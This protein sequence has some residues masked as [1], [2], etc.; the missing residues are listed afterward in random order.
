MTDLPFISNSTN[1]TGK[2]ADSIFRSGGQTKEFHPRPRIAA[3]KPQP[4]QRPTAADR[5]P[6]PQNGK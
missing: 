4:P 2:K 5:G 3:T 1:G 6:R